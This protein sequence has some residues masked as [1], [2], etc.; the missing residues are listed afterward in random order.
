MAA[1]DALRKMFGTGEDTAPIPYGDKARK[2]SQMINS[3]F[4]NFNNSNL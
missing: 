4:E 2:F 3:I 1:R